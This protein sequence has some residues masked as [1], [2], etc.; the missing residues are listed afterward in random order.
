MIDLTK[1]S[2]EL[3]TVALESN[4]RRYAADYKLSGHFVEAVRVRLG[5]DCAWLIPELDTV[6]EENWRPIV[7]GGA[8]AQSARECEPGLFDLGLAKD[9]LAKRRPKIP[10]TTIL[11]RVIRFGRQVGL[12][13]AVR[14]ERPFESADRR[15]LDRLAGVLATELGRR[16]KK[17]LYKVLDRI[18]EKIVAELRPRDLAYQILDG[19]EQLVGYDHSSAFLTWDAGAG[20]LRVEAEKIAWTK[21]KSAAVGREIPVS[22][23]AI[24]VIQSGLHLSTDRDG[25]PEHPAHDAVRRLL[26]DGPSPGIPPIRSLLVAPLFFDDRFLGLLE[27][28]AWKRRAFDGWDAEVVERFLPV[29]EVAIRN[30]QWNQ[31]LENQAAQAEVKAS[32]VTLARVVAHDVNNAVGVILPLAQQIQDDLRL[33]ELVP[34]EAGEDLAVIVDRA[35][36]CK[37]IF[38]NMLRAGST[39]RLGEGPVD[40]NR[41][42]RETVSFFEA[43]AARSGFELSLALDPEMPVVLFSRQDLEH[44]LLNLVTNSLEALR[45]S[46]KRIT[47]ETG[48]TE[49]GLAFLRVLDDGPGIPRHLRDKVLEPFF[50]TKEGGHGLGLALCRSLTWQNC[51]GFEIESEA[52]AGTTVTVEMRLFTPSEAASDPAPEAA[53]EVAPDGSEIPNVA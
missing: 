48:R 39:G 50:S 22:P 46:G 34:E 28:A 4:L 51:G 31:T 25:L 9:F 26:D 33:G 45:T 38:V 12:L 20:V 43:A 10:P 11:G 52:G 49:S 5:A 8:G 15:T 35:Q 41:S 40:L 37:R 13:G 42:V 32:L 7:R 19:L 29:A 36:F 21:A 14:R 47:V 2:P 27:V 16:E 6:D 17:R 1:V 30:A 23:E 18:K 44:V 53:V 3:F 24:F